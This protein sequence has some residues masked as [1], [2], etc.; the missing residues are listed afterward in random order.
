LKVF[1]FK[2]Q[3]KLSMKNRFYRYIT[4]L[5]IGGGGITVYNYTG[6][7]I[8]LED[9]TILETKELPTHLTKEYDKR[10]LNDTDSLTVFVHHTA[11]DADASIEGIA[12]YHVNHNG[13][14]GIGYHSAIEPDGDILLL[15]S[16]YTISYHTRGQNTKG[17]SVVML[18]N[19]DTET[20]ND[21]QIASLELVLNALCQVLPIKSIKG[22]RDAFSAHTSCPGNNA[23]NQIKHLFF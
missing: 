14:A 19:Y 13:W 16:L 17:I 12:R 2:N 3:Y 9:G 1:C 23:Y 5:L 15:N 7:D 22:H 11:V 10:P 4:A 6:T 18:G 21:K 8:V 20:L